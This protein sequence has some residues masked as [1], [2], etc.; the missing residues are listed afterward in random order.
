MAPPI[1]WNPSWPGQV[2]NEHRG[3]SYSN[4]VCNS[5]GN[6]VQRLN[7]RCTTTTPVTDVRIFSGASSGGQ[8]DTRYKS[9]YRPMIVEIFEAGDE[10][11]TI[12]DEFYIPDTVTNN[13][14]MWNNDFSTPLAP[15]YIQVADDG[16]GW[17]AQYNTGNGGIQFGGG[18]GNLST[19]PLTRTIHNI[20]FFIKTNA[21]FRLHRWGPGSPDQIYTT[22]YTDVP[23]LV[24]PGTGW[25][26]QDLGDVMVEDNGSN[27][28]FWQPE[29]VRNFATGGTRG[30]SISALAGG[31]GFWFLDA[32]HMYVQYSDSQRVAMGIGTPSNTS[33]NWVN[34][35]LTDADGTG[36]PTLTAGTDYVMLLRQPYSPTD[37]ASFTQTSLAWRDI[38]SQQGGANYSNWRGSTQV[39]YPLPPGIFIGSARGGYP[40]AQFLNGST[41]LEFSQNY[42]WQ[43]GAKVKSLSSMYA[44]QTI[45]ITGAAVSQTYGQVLA[46]V[47][48]PN[49]E[50]PP[51]DSRLRVEVLDSTGVRVLGP[52]ERTYDEMAVLPIDAT[53]G[54]VTTPTVES[55]DT[56]L[57]Y[58]RVRFLFDTPA[59]LPAGTYRIRFSSP[60]DLEG[61][62]FSIA[63][64]TSYKAGTPNR[65]FGAGDVQAFTATDYADGY[66][67]NFSNWNATDLDIHDADYD[68]DLLTVLATV[69]AGVEGLTAQQGVTTTHNAKVCPDCKNTGKKECNG[70]GDG[71]LPFAHLSWEPLTISGGT[72]DYY[73][74]DRQDS[75]T[76]NEQWERVAKVDGDIAYWTDYEVR[77]GISTRYRVRGVDTLGIPGEWSNIATV[78][79]GEYGGNLGNPLCF[80]SNFGVGMS[81][82]YPEVFGDTVERT[83]TFQESGDVTFASIYGRERQVA[84]RPMERKGISFER[85]LLLNAICS[86]SQ[87]TMDLFA[88]LRDLSWAPLPYVCVRDGEGNRWYAALQVSAGAN[89][90]PGEMWYAGITVTE[91]AAVAAVHDTTVPQVTS[92]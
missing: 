46:S 7:F 45:T 89:R 80:S 13:Q 43:R 72:L 27:W 39:R 12:E 2:G 56:G 31:G 91:V 92:V 67:S 75:L 64:V 5:V 11:F 62:Q 69:P 20:N 83:W 37:G 15:N 38:S 3:I 16:F 30:I 22:W 44:D 48:W 52:A 74:V 47:A 42:G 84:F 29:D 26:H 70:C 76:L 33:W 71:V 90:R 55:E 25:F 50:R 59:M 68:A 79:V 34:F 23:A 65:S 14:W 57:Q 78:M 51:L 32:V 35:D 85:T 66:S 17:V 58:R 9:L 41:V 81:V 88:P 63:C 19:F 24:S 18:S 10:Q 86:V 6:N 28:R 73:D 49:S 36:T 8:L 77:L 82:V 21:I 60:D 4:N 61:S 53:G 1:R 87:P 54:T 40:T